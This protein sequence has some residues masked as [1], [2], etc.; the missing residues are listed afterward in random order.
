[1]IES[2]RLNALLYKIVCVLPDSK[3]APIAKTA[4]TRLSRGFGNRLNA[5]EKEDIG[6][7]T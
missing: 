6:G 3:V 7:D 5:A 1:M 4:K 2:V